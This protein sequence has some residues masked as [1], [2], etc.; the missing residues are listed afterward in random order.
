VQIGLEP[1]DWNQVPSSRVPCTDPGCVTNSGS[2][3]FLIPLYCIELHGIC[4]SHRV[5]NHD[6]KALSE[7]FSPR[8]SEAQAFRHVKFPFEFLW[9][10][11]FLLT[12]HLCLSFS[13]FGV[14]QCTCQCTNMSGRLQPFFRL[15]ENDQG[16]V[17]VVV[18]LCTI[19]IT[20]TVSAIRS[21]V[22][23]RQRVEFQRDDAT[24]YLGSVSFDVTYARYISCHF[25]L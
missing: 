13:D 25:L 17:A 4:C 10:D 15:T 23:S 7:I 12:S 16:G 3:S 8:R 22:A 2:R 14:V 6:L 20:S 5:A 11:R 1:L 21:L 9:T 24:F 19:V 18:A